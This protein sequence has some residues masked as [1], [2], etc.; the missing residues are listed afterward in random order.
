MTK[1]IGF[2]KNPKIPVNSRIIV[3]RKVEEVKERKPFNLSETIAIISSTLVS[4]LVAS[5]L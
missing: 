3:N 2:L 1:K 4:V 5:K